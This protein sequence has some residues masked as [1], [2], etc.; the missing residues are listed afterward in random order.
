MVAR[1]NALRKNAI[2]P[3]LLD[4]IR[5]WETARTSGAFTQAQQDSLKNTRKEFHLEKIAEGKWQM[6]TY[7]TSQAFTHEKYERQ[8][9][10]PTLASWSYSQTGDT[11]PL[12]FRMTA[13]GKAGSIKNIKLQIDNYAEITIPIE[14]QAGETIVC[15]GTQRLQVYTETGKYKTSF[16]LTAVPPTLST[17]THH[18][19]FDCTFMGD[20]TPKVD[21]QFRQLSHKEM[22]S[23]SK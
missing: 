19:V 13:N 21:M 23:A 10:E 1:P 11:Q 17:A 15:D 18:M 16:Q 22:V 14:L 2:T 20:K 6:Y 3:A 5:E 7:N 9:G 8:P 4:A 12:Q